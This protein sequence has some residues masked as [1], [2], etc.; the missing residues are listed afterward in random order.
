MAVQLLF[1]GTWV[2]SIDEAEVAAFIATNPIDGVVIHNSEKNVFQYYDDATQTMK[3]M[4]GSEYNE[5][6]KI[7]AD[8][9]SGGTYT[10]AALIGAELLDVSLNGFGL[11]IDAGT[12]TPAAQKVNFDDTTGTLYFPQDLTGCW[13]RIIYKGATPIITIT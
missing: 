10:N 1:G 6:F 11:W 3:N 5:G 2:W 4:E 13:F 12:G 8:G 9:L 7:Q